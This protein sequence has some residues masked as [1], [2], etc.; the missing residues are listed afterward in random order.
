MDGSQLFAQ[1]AEAF[2]RQHDAL[3]RQFQQP[4]R[5]MSVCEV[6]G[7]FINSTDND[8]RR[9]VWSAL[10]PGTHFSPA[11]SDAATATAQAHAGSSAP[12]SNSVRPVLELAQ[13]CGQL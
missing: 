5:T 13:H 4:E 9:A 6:C 3:H 11:A 1:Q 7:V 10:H 8:Q 12:M 2:K